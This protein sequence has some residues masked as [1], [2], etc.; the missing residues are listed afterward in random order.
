MGVLQSATGP[1]LV[2]CLGTWL[3]RRIDTHGAWDDEQSWAAVQ[4]DVDGLVA[5]L[6][7]VR[8]PVVVV[9][10]EVGSG[11]VPATASGRRFRDALGR[12]NTAVAAECESVVLVVAGRALPLR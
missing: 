3:T 5:A 2:D 12:L 10:N 7:R 9:S 8:V 4:S 6:R 1:L 11:V